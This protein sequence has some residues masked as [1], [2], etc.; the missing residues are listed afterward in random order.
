MCRVSEPFSFERLRVCFSL[1]P[2]LE[3]LPVVF[4]LEGTVYEMTKITFNTCIH[5]F[6][7][8]CSQ[9]SVYKYN[10]VIAF[11]FSNYGTGTKLKFKLEPN[12]LAPGGSGSETLLI[13]PSWCC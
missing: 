1:A 12:I 2:A 10:T 4:L 6:Y 9:L 13:G 5:S 3:D 7:F 11:K 8:I